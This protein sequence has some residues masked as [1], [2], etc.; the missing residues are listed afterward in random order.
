MALKKDIT[1]EKGV[2]TRYYRIKGIELEGGK[3]RVKLHSYVNQTTRDS[4]KN[5]IEQNAKAQAYQDSLNAIR[6]ELD[7]LVGNSDEDD[8]VRELTDQVNAMESNPDRP[9]FTTIVDT[10][11]GE[12][13]VVIDNVETLSLEAIYEKLIADG[14]YAGSESV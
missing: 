6:A 5:A 2:K 10:H 7:S 4:E 9:A 1:D 13:E 14:K 12:D 11:Y 3:I 8:R